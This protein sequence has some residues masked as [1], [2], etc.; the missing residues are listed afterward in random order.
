MTVNTNGE[1]PA[2]HS[3]VV[4]LHQKDNDG[5]YINTARVPTSSDGVY[6]FLLNGCAE[7]SYCVKAIVERSDG[8]A[9]AET[10]YYF[11]IQ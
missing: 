10:P 2:E 6:S 8:Y 5:T 1:L 9:V 7:G 4:Q 11:I 3:V